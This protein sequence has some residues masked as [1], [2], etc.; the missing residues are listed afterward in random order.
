MH[1]CISAH[2]VY[3]LL[4]NQCARTKCRWQL[5]SM[6]YCVGQN[7]LERSFSETEKHQL[8]FYLQCRWKHGSY[9]WI[10]GLTKHTDPPVGG[11]IFMPETYSKSCVDLVQFNC[12][13]HVPWQNSYIV[14]WKQDWLQLLALHW[15]WL[16][17]MKM[18]NGRHLL[19]V[20]WAKSLHFDDLIVALSVI[21][22]I[23]PFS[24]VVHNIVGVQYW[25]PRHCHA[26]T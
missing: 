2:M 9:L 10:F 4:P 7:L 19:Q 21:E 8:I 14:S 5:T 23:A 15:P 11:T 1:L 26:R 6:V 25:D 13:A 17:S 3:G 12:N 24:K 16:A 20:F 18:F 22:G